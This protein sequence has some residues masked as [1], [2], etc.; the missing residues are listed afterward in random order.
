M[1]STFNRL[2][3]AT[4]TSQNVKIAR[5][6]LLCANGFQPRTVYKHGSDDALWVG[7]TSSPDRFAAQK[8]IVCQV[9]KLDGS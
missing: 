9:N 5:E 6:Q 8:Q 3:S 7:S 1:K 4:E 2:Y